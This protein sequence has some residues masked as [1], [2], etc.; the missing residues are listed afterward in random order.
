LAHH[1]Q[2]VS[3]QSLKRDSEAGELHAR[4]RTHRKCTYR[5]HERRKSVSE[6]PD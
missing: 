4:V 2:V 1:F 5:R 3:R 6:C